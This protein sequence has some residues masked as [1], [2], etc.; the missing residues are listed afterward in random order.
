MADKR[1]REPIDIHSESFLHELMRRQLKLSTGCALAFVLILFGLP[2]LNYF[3]PD[4]MATS[5]FG[6]TMTWLFLGVL[7]F[8]LVWIISAVFI[9][10]SIALEEDEVRE[11]EASRRGEQV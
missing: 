11:V 10:R 4:F 7:V 1:T 8:P 5:I 3:L 2:L 9:R 6:F